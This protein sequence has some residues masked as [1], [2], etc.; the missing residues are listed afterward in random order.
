MPENAADVK[1]LRETVSFVDVESERMLREGLNLLIEEAGFYGEESGRSGNQD[2]TWIVDPLD[3]TTNYLSGL[4]HF[5][6]SIALVE[7]ENTI[8]GV[9]HKPF[10]GEVYSSVSKQG[11]FYN[12]KPSQPFQLEMPAS[13]ALFMTG[14]P[15]RSP[16]VAEQ[17]FKTAP[18]VLQLGRGIRRSGSA[19]LD[20]ANLGL[21]HIQG[22]WETDLQPYDVA[23][24]VLMM[25]ENGIVVTNQKGDPYNMFNDRI[26][27][28]AF[29]K[30]H[31][32]LLAAVQ[33]GYNI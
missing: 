16:D 1:A 23:A 14:F 4:D 26:L 22:F 6:I 13:D 21:G 3:G 8:L 31:E 29:P 33:K 18:E 30:V 11:V 20:L 10:T 2:L 25:L 24:G 32:E 5:S 15:Y 27:V 28:A 12:G 7:N 19:A 17:F 9:I